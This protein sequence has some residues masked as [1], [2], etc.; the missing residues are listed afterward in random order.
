VDKEFLLE[1]VWYNFCNTIC[2]LTE[3]ESKVVDSPSLPQEL[4]DNYIKSRTKKYV[5]TRDIEHFCLEVL[6]Q[7][8]YW[9]QGGYHAFAASIEELVRD[10]VMSPVKASGLNGRDPAL[11]EK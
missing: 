5:F 3:R 8:G 1:T 11:Y 10:G 4:V 7:E 6:G 9:K 2:K